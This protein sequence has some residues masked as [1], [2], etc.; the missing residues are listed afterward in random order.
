[1]LGKKCWQS[2]R[3]DQ[4]VTLSHSFYACNKDETLQNSCESYVRWLFFKH[5]RKL[6]LELLRECALYSWEKWNHYTSGSLYLPGVFKW[7]WT[8]RIQNDKLQT[9][10]LLNR[11]QCI[12][13]LS[14]T[15]RMF[16]LFLFIHIVQFAIISFYFI[17]LLLQ[18]EYVTELRVDSE[19]KYLIFKQYK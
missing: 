18:K 11:L 10:V 7:V 13:F 17:Y 19:N 5:T 12:V 9:A 14:L 3:T 2:S 6:T 4:R 8:S 15:L 16:S 1:M